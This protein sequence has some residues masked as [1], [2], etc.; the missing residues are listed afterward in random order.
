MPTLWESAKEKLGV[1][2]VTG[3]VSLVTIFS[4][5][6]VGSIKTEVKDSLQNRSANCMP[7]CNVY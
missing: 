4:D 5:R 2:L 6:I 7:E 3:V 1:V